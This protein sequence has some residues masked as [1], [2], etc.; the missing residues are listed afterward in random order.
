MSEGLKN[1]GG[2]WLKEGAKGK[3]MSGEI[4]LGGVKQ[5]ILIFRN[6]KD[7]VEKRPDYRIYISQEE[8][9]IPPEESGFPQDEFK[10]DKFPDIPF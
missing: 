7:G 3:F 1:V 5:H 8:K 6:D 2:L 9:P 10:D 4:E